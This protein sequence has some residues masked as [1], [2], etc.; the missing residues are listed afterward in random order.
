[1]NTR[2]IYGEYEQR[3]AELPHLIWQ[4]L[5][6]YADANEITLEK[7]IEIACHK[8]LFMSGLFPIGLGNQTQIRVK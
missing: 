7:V 2:N 4:A 3:P 5:Q 1:M 6:A 8:Y